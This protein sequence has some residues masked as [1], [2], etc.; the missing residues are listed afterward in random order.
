MSGSNPDPAEAKQTPVNRSWVLRFGSKYGGTKSLI[1]VYEAVLFYYIYIFQQQKRI[2]K[3]EKYKSRNRNVCALMKMFG[4]YNIYEKLAYVIS[5]EAAV[6]EPSGRAPVIKVRTV[7]REVASERS[8]DVVIVS[9]INCG[10]T[11][12][13]NRRYRIVIQWIVK[14]SS[15][16]NGS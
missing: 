5:D 6:G 16:T 12:N 10:I 7:R 9:R 4:L 11:E 13:K 2:N 1:P 15:F 8:I 3:W 14:L